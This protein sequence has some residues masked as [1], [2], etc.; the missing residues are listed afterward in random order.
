MKKNVLRVL[1]CLLCVL[2]VLPVVPA[3]AAVSFDQQRGSYTFET[4][5]DLKT[6][7][8]QTFDQQTWAYYIGEGTLVIDED[9]TFPENLIVYGYEESVHI[10]Q[11]VTVTLYALRMR[12]IVVD[13]TLTVTNDI[14]AFRNGS[15]T[16]NGKLIVT[17]SEGSV[18]TQN[19]EPIR[20]E[21]NI[22]WGDDQ[23]WL[24]Q[25]VYVSD[26]ADFLAMVELVKSEAR[27]RY[28]CYVIV[29]SGEVELTGDVT[30]PQH[31]L[32]DI[33]PAGKLTVGSGC[34]LTVNGRTFVEGKLTVEGNL[35]NH[36]YAWLYD[37]ADMQIDEKTGSYGGSGMLKV[38]LAESD[39]LSERVPGLDLKKC[40]FS[41]P[42][43]EGWCEIRWAEDMFT[44]VA[45]DAFYF[46]PVQWAVKGGITT[47]T[48]M[49]TFSPDA[50]CTRGQVVTFL[51]RAAG[52]PEPSSLYNPF[53][54]V[55]EADYYYKAV[56][57]AV[58]KGITN[59]LSAT[60]FGPNEVCN[61]G[62]VATFLHRY[63]NRPSHSG[64]NPFTDVNQQDY[65]Y[66]PVLWAVESGITNGMGDGIFAPGATCTRGQIVTFLFRAIGE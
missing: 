56:L 21:E 16:V 46:A 28:E 27:P 63:A 10:P 55:T 41:K 58:E 13:G 4:L 50:A 65:F 48:A 1:A 47:G 40:L 29:E 66:N 23:A 11:G 53:G 59:G 51:W 54:D 19:R 44:D 52:C 36:G 32:L 20:G 3:N 24:T 15:F 26:T 8:N 43:G 31:A 38:Y 35:E 5:E 62:Q 42:E 37:N 64:R 57:W 22:V 9:L 2:L 34:T 33:W 12:N 17:G 39:S 18:A 61:R 25:C 6:L 14:I 60:A 49:T 30:L 45:K 7:M